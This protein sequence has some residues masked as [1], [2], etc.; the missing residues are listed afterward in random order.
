LEIKDRYFTD[1]LEVLDTG[2]LGTILQPGGVA[3]LF[4]ASEALPTGLID[5][6]PAAD[7]DE[8]KY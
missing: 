6:L 3:A 7:T 8:T 4:T 5:E 2:I 1:A